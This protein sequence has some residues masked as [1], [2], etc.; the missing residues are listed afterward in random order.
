MWRSCDVIFRVRALMTSSV[1]ISSIYDVIWWS[2]VFL[3]FVQRSIGPV[4]RPMSVRPLAGVFLEN[5]SWDLSENLA[6]SSRTIVHATT[7][8]AGCYGKKS[9]SAENYK[10]RSNKGFWEYFGNCNTDF[11]H[12]W[13]ERA[14]QP[15]CV[16]G[17]NFFPKF[18][19]KKWK[20]LF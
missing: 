1:V 6:W 17:W 15:S 5:R 7:D 9:G 19:K 12:F 20:K 14:K 10:N 18:K 8:E 2:N 16:S 3:S 13:S 11:V 4:D